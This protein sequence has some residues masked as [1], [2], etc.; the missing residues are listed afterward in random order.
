MKRKIDC[1][2]AS[3]NLAQPTQALDTQSA[4]SSQ[5][6]PIAIQ[7]DHLPSGLTRQ[8]EL[9][10]VHHYIRSAQIDTARHDSNSELWKDMPFSDG[11][12]HEFVLD[13]VLALAALHKS[14][15]D[16]D[17]SKRYALAC[18]HYQSRGFRAYQSCLTSIDEDNCHAMFSTSAL[19]NIINIAM[20][21]GGP[22]LL[23]TPPLETILANFK[24]LRGIKI[25]LSD[26]WDTVKEA[27]YKPIF[28]ERVV[29][30]DATLDKEVAFLL[31]E[32]RQQAHDVVGSTKSSNL[33]LYHA[34][35]DSLEVTFKKLEYCMDVGA[36]V[37]WPTFLKEESEDLLRNHDP[38]MLLIFI[39]YGVLYLQ[40][41]DRWWAEDFGRRIIF[42]FSEILHA[43]DASWLPLTSWARAKAAS[44]ESSNSR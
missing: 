12:K 15:V 31:G 4:S 11:L 36:V 20:S 30:I 10:L 21:R 13:A 17:N 26:T 39:H 18:L 14:F 5:E 3:R 25:V 32:L 19:I 44:L 35:I 34:A 27:H 24:L 2:Y 8:E 43:I 1:S 23:A 37:G 7:A 33:E 29:P 16:F 9:C 40:L 41:H 42:G 28:S 38:M 22:S 6:R